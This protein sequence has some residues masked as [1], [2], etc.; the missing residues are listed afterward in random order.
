[1]P[2]KPETIKQILVVR[3]DRI[4]DVLLNVPAIRALKETFKARITLLAHRELKT[5]FEAI[6][7]VDEVIAYDEERCQS[8]LVERWRFLQLVRRRHFGLAVILNPSRQMH[9][10][11]FAAGIPCRLG[12]HRKWGFLL[13]HSI[14]DKKY[15]GQK[16]E[17][18]YN[19]DLVRAIGA[20]TQDLRI[21]LGR[22]AEEEAYVAQLCQK[23]ALSP[24]ATLVAIAPNT[25][26]PA[27]C[28]PKEY[29]AQLIDRLIGEGGVK[30]AVIGAPQEHSAVIRLLAMTK[31]LP[32]NLCGKL[33]L[34]QL[35][36]FLARAQLLIA[37]DSGPVHLA[38]A[39]DTP[40]IVIFG[41]NIPGVGPRRWGPWGKGHT[42]LHKDPGCSPCL[43]RA[44]ADNF[45][46]L[47]LI[48]P[49]EVFATAQMKLKDRR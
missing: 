6:P 16:H 5:L 2:I 31:Q 27:K 21:T 13:T 9:I 45:K 49:E 30:V 26:N 7:E 25:S 24:A 10:L 4:G 43:D 42:V 15:E 48:T 37:N 46:C 18:E 28:W 17:V 35:A 47:R 41:R 19:L 29:F 20:D 1:M 23:Y 40:A 36:A 33:N 12:Y 34:R 39:V 38:A 32:I 22:L 11:A 8:S 44:C 14:A 3:T